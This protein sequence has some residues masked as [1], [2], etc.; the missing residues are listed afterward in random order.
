MTISASL[1]ISVGHEDTAQKKTTAYIAL[2]V[3]TAEA[4]QFSIL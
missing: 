1:N 4:I 2:A 3:M